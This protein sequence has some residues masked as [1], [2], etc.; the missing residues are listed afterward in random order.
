MSDPLKLDNRELAEWCIAEYEA[1]DPEAHVEYRVEV[2]IAVRLAREVLRLSGDPA[3]AG[4]CE[5]CERAAIKRCDALRADAVRYRRLRDIGCA[6]ADTEHLK[7]GLVNRAT[8]LDAEV[9]ADLA[10]YP[11]A[12]AYRAA[13]DGE[14]LRTA[15]RDALREA[16]EEVREYVRPLMV[17]SNLALTIYEIAQDVLDNEGETG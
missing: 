7:Q 5:C 13:F 17:S 15:D 8:N 12:G 1:I 4:V 14:V 9:D 10:V 11:P 2:W 6:L 3:A 16:L